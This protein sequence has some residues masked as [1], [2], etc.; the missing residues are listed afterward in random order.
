MW[1]SSLQRASLPLAESFVCSTCLGL[2]CAD[3]SA[4]GTAEQKAA[5][6]GSVSAPTACKT[7]ELTLSIVAV[8]SVRKTCARGRTGSR[9]YLTT[10]EEPVAPAISKAVLREEPE[11]ES[12]GSASEGDG[13][14]YPS[15]HILL[16]KFICC[17]FPLLFICSMT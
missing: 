17:V 14:Q 5:S 15:Q 8:T 3:H 1:L 16:L 9:R 10:W 13:A 4:F 11:N 2:L 6:C 7:D 12:D